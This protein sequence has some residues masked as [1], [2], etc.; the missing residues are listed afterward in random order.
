MRDARAARQQPVIAKDH[1]V[2]AAQVLHQA[3]LLAAIEGGALVV[4][5]A[6]AGQHEQRVLGDRQQPRALGGH[7][8]AGSR[9]RV[10]HA[11][12]VVPGGVDGAVDHEAG[13]VHRKRRV[14][15][16]LAVEVD[17]DQAGGADLV[18]EDAVG[19]DEELVLGPRHAQ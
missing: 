9:V 14:H 2:V 13:R 8:D 5:V 16:L 18:E 10:Q 7:R 19:V 12:G 1:G 4:V 11:L 6:E 3:L 17:L 15:D